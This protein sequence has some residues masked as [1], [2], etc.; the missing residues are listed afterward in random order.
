MSA[1][2]SCKCENTMK[3]IF[4]CHSRLSSGDTSRQ[5]EKKSLSNWHVIAFLN[6]HEVPYQAHL[7]FYC[8]LYCILTARGC[9]RLPRPKPE[10]PRPSANP[11]WH[12]F[13]MW[14]RKKLCRCCLAFSSFV[15]PVAFP[16]LHSYTMLTELI[17]VCK[18]WNTVYLDKAKWK[19]VINVSQKRK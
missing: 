18:N 3:C 1:Y 16:L 11:W 15:A 9:L 12:T 14:S 19:V 8:I 5:S 4:I 2:L 6:C 7:N 17:F 13:N 10:G